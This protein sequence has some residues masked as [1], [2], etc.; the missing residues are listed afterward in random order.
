MRN[1]IQSP[2]RLAAFEG[3]A[4]P[5]KYRQQ[6]LSRDIYGVAKAALDELDAMREGDVSLYRTALGVHVVRNA[7]VA[8]ELRNRLS[9]AAF[10]VLG[11]EASPDTESEMT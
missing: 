3:E 5:E 4:M 2:L 9:A 11:H 1:P 7:L 10:P 8:I 6:R